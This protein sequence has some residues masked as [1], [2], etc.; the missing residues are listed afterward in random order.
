MRGSMLRVAGSASPV[1]ASGSGH[2]RSDG[3]ATAGAV[4][5]RKLD[6]AGGVPR[7][8]RGQLVG[9]QT[10]GRYH[11]GAQLQQ[12]QVPAIRLGRAGGVRDACRIGGFR[13]D[14]EHKLVDIRAAIGEHG[15]VRAVGAI[16]RDRAARRTDDGSRQQAAC[17]PPGKFDQRDWVMRA[18]WALRTTVTQY[19]RPGCT[20]RN[21]RNKPCAGLLLRRVSAGFENCWDQVEAHREALTMPD[22]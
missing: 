14:C 7:D 4:P 1:T 18:E 8:S 19:H 17:G 13:R 20:G 5:D 22:R 3:G 16:E 10:A 9:S 6:D 21:A 12:A 15:P 2:R 11:F